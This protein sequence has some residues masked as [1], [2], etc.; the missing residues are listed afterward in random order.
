MNLKTVREI[1][2]SPDM[3]WRLGKTDPEWS[4]ALNEVMDLGLIPHQQNTHTANVGEAEIWIANWPYCFGHLYGNSSGLP[5]RATAIRLK[6]YLEQH[7]V[8]I[9]R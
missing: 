5:D 1:I 9:I 7:G 8:V 6:E 4:Q 2:T 3:W